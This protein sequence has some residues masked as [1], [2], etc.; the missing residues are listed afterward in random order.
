MCRPVSWRLWKNG[1]SNKQDKDLKSHSLIN[2]LRRLLQL[3]KPHPQRHLGKYSRGVRV[4]YYQPAPMISGQSGQHL[5]VDHMDTN[6]EIAKE[7]GAE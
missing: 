7:G 4:W 5:S 2:M 6:L 1:A 3:A